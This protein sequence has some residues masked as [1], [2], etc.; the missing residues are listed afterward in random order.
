MDAVNQMALEMCMEYYNE[1]FQVVYGVHWEETKKLHIHFAAN[2]VNYI[3][4][5]KFDTSV[6]GN[7]YRK[8]RFNEIM[9]EYYNRT[10]IYFYGNV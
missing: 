6:T 1:G 4:G 2:A 3:T 9:K 10:A 7:L 8:H 5:R